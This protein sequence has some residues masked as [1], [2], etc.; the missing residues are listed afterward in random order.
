MGREVRR[1]P[2]SW[3]HPCD[4]RGLVPMFDEHIDDA[5]EEWLADLDRVRRGDWTDYERGLYPTLADW[6]SDNPAPRKEYYR[7]WREDEAT[8]YQV[9]ENVT[10][11]TPISPAFATRE[12]LIEYLVEG[13]DDWDR[14][15]GRRG[16]PREAAT[17]F[18]N[19]GWAPSFVVT[20][21][22]VLCGIE[23][24]KDKP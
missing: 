4:E 8:W 22:A 12:E 21:A 2:P 11:G 10:E 1:V 3:Q 19:A 6:L 17:A 15:R 23:A 20:A 13:G 14:A 9:W 16:Y 5:L 18:V 24:A 7:P